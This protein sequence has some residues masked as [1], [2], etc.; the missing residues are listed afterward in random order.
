M[1][2]EQKIKLEEQLK[3][4]DDKIQNLQKRM[5]ALERKLESR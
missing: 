2:P 5:E 4:K 1:T 3:D